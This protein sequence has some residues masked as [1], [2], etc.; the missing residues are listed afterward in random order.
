[1]NRERVR[2]A[3]FIALLL[4]MGGVT[5]LMFLP[6][7]VT[8]AVAAAVTVIVHPLYRVMVRW[9]RGYERIAA[10]VTVLL[11]VLI[12]LIPISILGTQLVLEA[13]DVYTNIGSQGSHV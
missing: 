3:V 8:L 12:V 6:Y 9:L 2:T 1:M 7:L 10:L 4:G 13:R 5:L 11:T